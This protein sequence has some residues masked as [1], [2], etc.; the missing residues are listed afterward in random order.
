MATPALG[1]SLYYDHGQHHVLRD[2]VYGDDLS[3]SL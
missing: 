1:K 3:S 2:S